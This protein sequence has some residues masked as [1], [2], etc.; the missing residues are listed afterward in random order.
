MDGGKLMSNIRKILISLCVAVTSSGAIAQAAD[1][2][3]A[4][5]PAGNTPPA[6]AQK[7]APAEPMGMGRTGDMAG[8][9]EHMKAMQ[10]M[11]EKMAAA[12]TPE[13]RQALMAEHSKLMQKGMGM[14]RQMGC[15]MQGG[16]GVSS[17]MDDHGQMMEKCMNMMGSMMQMMMDRMPA[18]QPSK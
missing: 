4:H 14:M 9:D 3:N 13:E 18:Q 12:K 16:Q 6:A 7:S 15:N 1:E 11:H 5:H 17:D 10:L 8:M 2:H